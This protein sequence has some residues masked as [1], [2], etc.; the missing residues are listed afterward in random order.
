MTN[1]SVCKR[2]FVQNKT[3]S[4]DIREKEVVDHHR[5]PRLQNENK[6]DGKGKAPHT[7]GT[8]RSGKKYKPHASI[9]KE[10]NARMDRLVI[11]GTRLCVETSTHRKIVSMVTNASTCM[12]RMVLRGG[13]FWSDCDANPGQCDVSAKTANV[14]STTIYD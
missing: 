2:G 4:R 1:G 12:K 10:G 6:S 14:G 8:N 3:R 13:I 5:R 11:T 9:S 7:T